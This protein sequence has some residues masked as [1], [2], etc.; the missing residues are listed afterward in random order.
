MEPG[1]IAEWGSFV[2]AGLALAVSIFSASRSSDEKRWAENSRHHAELYAQVHD[3]TA[4]IAALQAD[5]EH[6]PNKD[7]TYRLE[8]SMAR[9]EGELKV[10][11]ES[12]KPVARISERLQ[13]FLLE[14]ATE[15]R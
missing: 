4:R 14:Q 6:V 11:A 1:V 2:V 12:L 7:V 13:E 10:M 9:L 8:T 3:H 15:R 5:L